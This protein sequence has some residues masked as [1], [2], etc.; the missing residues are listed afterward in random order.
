MKKKQTINIFIKNIFKL[1]KGII[2][3]ILV[4]FAINILIQY[5]ASEKVVSKMISD[6]GYLILSLVLMII[7]AN[8]NINI[9]KHIAVPMYIFSILL[10][11]LVLFAGVSSHGAKRWINLGLKFQPSELCKISVPLMICYYLNLKNNIIKY[12]DY[13]VG[14]ILTVIPFILIIKQPDL[15]T[16]ILVLCSGLLVLF[17]FGI[18]WKIILGNIFLALSGA[19]IIWHF[20]YDYQKFRILTLLNPQSDKLGKG[21]H[22]IQG[23]IGIGSGG[24]I[25][26]G[27]LSGT[28]IHLDFIPEKNTDFVVSV[29]AEEFGYLGIV[30][31]LTL[32]LILIL[33]CIGIM[34]NAKD[35]NSQALIGSLTLSF[36]LYVFINM[37]MVA[38]I[39]PVVGVPLPFISYGGTATLVLA[40]QFGIVLLIAKE[41]N[42]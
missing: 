4:L 22:I 27:Y 14:F 18:S 24:F 10:L 39:V 21:Y 9:L 34:V 7:I 19:P 40:L 32:Y 5:S 6:I 36:C 37:G 33:K 8:L 17:Y 31:V 29:I 23:I 3:I 28:Q 30:L 13:F 11:L 26:K 38:G 15:G 42:Y 35:S 41:N 25:G 1:D 12:S 16:G 2:F 20:L